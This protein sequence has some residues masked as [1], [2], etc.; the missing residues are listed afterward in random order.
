MWGWLRRR[1]RTGNALRSGFAGEH[2]R[3]KP[4]SSRLLLLTLNKHGPQTSPAYC[5][6]RP[7]AT[8]VCVR[9]RVCW[10]STVSWTFCRDIKWKAWMMLVSFS[11]H[12]SKFGNNKFCICMCTRPRHIETAFSKDSFESDLYCFTKLWHGI[13]E[14]RKC[15]S[16]RPLKVAQVFRLWHSSVYIY[17]F[18]P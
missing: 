14:W 13:T 5:G 17:I 3:T 4:T 18:L 6:N 16:V 7:H 10:T 1:V 15:K 2:Q 9:N 8:K 12:L 11:Q